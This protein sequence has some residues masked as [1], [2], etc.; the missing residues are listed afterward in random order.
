MVAFCGSVRSTSTSERSE[1]GKNCCCTWPIPTTASPIR[2]TQAITVIQRSRIAT[3][4]AAMKARVNRPCFS[5]WCFMVL[6]RMVTPSSGANSTA[7]TQETSSE[8]AITTN[9]E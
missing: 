8:A 2:T 1:E 9:S 3:C 5:E 4:R 7:T 6:G